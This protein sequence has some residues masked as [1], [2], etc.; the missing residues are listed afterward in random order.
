MP[1]EFSSQP[2]DAS[3]GANA[4]AG[5]VQ[6]AAASLKQRLN[7]HVTKARIAWSRGDKAEEQ[8]AFKAIITDNEGWMLFEAL[9]RVP[10]QRAHD[11]VAEA[12]VSLLLLVRSDKP[13]GDAKAALGK[14]VLARAVDEHRRIGREEAV[15]PDHQALVGGKREISSPEQ[16]AIDRLV[17][18]TIL[19]KL[20]P[21]E[22][23]ILWLRYGLG[24]SVEQTIRS[25][26]FSRDQVKKRCAAGI[27]RAKEV[28]RNAE[29]IE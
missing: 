16:M 11:V 13:I 8:A 27:N 29:F 17:A 21:D 2:Q 6:G 5:F 25:T 26:G 23:R 12:F 28:M 9:K 22:R 7:L 18:N 19:E 10:P 24:L 1:P 15:A 3:D 14:I 20:P 4:Y